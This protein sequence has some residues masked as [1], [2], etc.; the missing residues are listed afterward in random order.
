MQVRNSRASSVWT[1]IRSCA[2][3]W[4]HSG[5]AWVASS[6]FRSG[7]MRAMTFRPR[8]FAAAKQSPKK[9]RVPRNLPLRWNG[10]LVW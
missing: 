1:T 4:N 3:R 10:T 6:Q 5:W 7:L 2:S 9:S 8:F